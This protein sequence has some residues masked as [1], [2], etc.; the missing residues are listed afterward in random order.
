[1][2]YLRIALHKLLRKGVGPRGQIKGGRVTG[3]AACLQRLFPSPLSSEGRYASTSS[4]C[5]N[6]R[7]VEARNRPPK[8]SLRERARKDPNNQQDPFVVVVINA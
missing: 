4:I 7:V 1:M 3:W 5:R 2:V 8:R 6:S